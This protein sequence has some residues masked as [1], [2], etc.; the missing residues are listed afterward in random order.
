MS[1]WK[2]KGAG[3]QGLASPS[4]RALDITKEKSKKIVGERVR[5][6]YDSIISENKN[7]VLVVTH[8]A[9]IKNLIKNIFNIKEISQNIIT[10]VGN[11]TLTI[12]DVSNDKSELILSYDNSHLK[13]LYIN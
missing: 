10:E 3:L 8:G 9:V 1:A 4:F 11:C 12:I 13:D 2:T 7:D 5:I 6:I